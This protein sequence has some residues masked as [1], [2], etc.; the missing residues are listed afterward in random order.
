[1]SHLLFENDYYFF[2]RATKSEITT[3]KNII[4]RY[5]RI[6]DQA[7]N[8]NKSSV[9]FSPNINE[10]GRKRAYEI[11]EV[12]EVFEPG[13]YMGVPMRVGKNKKTVFYFLRDR[14][15]QKL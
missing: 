9:I 1:M 8:F 14:V 6:S 15:G 2:F 12:G 3:M 10:D 13:K 4:Q 5:E 7:I 11:L